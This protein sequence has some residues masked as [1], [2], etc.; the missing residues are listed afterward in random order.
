RDALRL[1]AVACLE[2]SPELDPELRERIEAAVAS[3]LP[4]RTMTAARSLAMAGSFTLDLLAKA[5]PATAAEVAATIRAAAEIGDPAALPMLAR[6]GRD[7]RR[8]VVRELVSAWS[9]FDP[10]EYAR[11]VLPDHPLDNE[12]WFDVPDVRL[13]PGLKH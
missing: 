3:L 13:V 6:F 2:S 1:V 4:P 5:S 12:L 11:L 7:P 9:R 8:A 10:E